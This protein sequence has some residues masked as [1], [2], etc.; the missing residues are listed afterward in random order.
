EGHR[1]RAGARV[2]DGLRGRRSTSSGGGRDAQRGGGAVRRVASRR[3]A[4]EHW[5]RYRR[6]GDR[7]G[8]ERGGSAVV[9]PRCQLAARSA[10]EARREA[11]AVP[12]LHQSG[13]TPQRTAREVVPRDR[14]RV[15]RA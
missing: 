8:E 11:G 9:G 7:R 13:T 6:G 5:P 15:A 10:V 1:S 2:R 12:C 3:G 4:E 14:E